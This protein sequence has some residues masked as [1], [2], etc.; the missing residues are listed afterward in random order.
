MKL[1]LLFKST[2]ALIVSAFLVSGVF[3]QTGVSINSSGT[4]PDADAV[5]DV[6]ASDKGVLLPRVTD[7]TALTPNPGGDYGLLVFDTTSNSY[8]YWSGTAW[9]EILVGDDQ[10]LAE[11]LAQG[12]SAGANGINMNN[13]AI[14]NI[15][16]ANSDDG[17]GS[18]LDADL[19]DGQEG[20]YYLD[21]DN[22]SY[23]GGTTL[24][25]STV[26]AAIDALDNAVDG[27]TATNG[28]TEA[29]TGVIK[30]GGA[31]TENTT[32]NGGAFDMDFTTTDVDGFSIDGTTFSVDGTNN[33][34]GIGTATPSQPLQINVDNNGLNIPLLLRNE[35]GTQGGNMVGMGFINEANGDW[36]K[37]AIVHERQGGFG[38]GDMHFLLDNTAD[39]SAVTLADVKMTILGSGNVG[40]GTAGPTHQLEI[41]GTNSAPMRV[42]SSS[43]ESD[44]AFTNGANGSWQA[45][46]NDSGNGTNSN[47][48]YIYDSGGAGYVASFQKGT[49][50]VGIGTSTPGAK[51]HVDNGTNT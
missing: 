11:V 2:F 4:P 27:I 34:I 40:I 3:A 29:P 25:S 49:G 28:L 33:R 22:G 45:G 1:S 41:H 12:N 18:L 10:T 47:Q 36:A 46:T 26:E 21:A 32:V 24:P 15:D 50:N 48:F 30:L 5:L 9:V 38:I 17:T 43:S 14:T 16:W 19:L 35:D 6:S 44:I 42:H 7:H 37:A 51:L 39:N 23:D 31:L 13:Q 8:W 20:T